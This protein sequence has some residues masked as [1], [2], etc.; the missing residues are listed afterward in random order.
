MADD[1]DETFFEPDLDAEL[2]Q[3][4]D[5]YGLRFG[6]QSIEIGEVRLGK[7]DINLK[8]EHG[9]Q[10]TTC[11]AWGIIHNQPVIISLCIPVQNFRVGE[12]P[13]VCVDQKR[14]I[15]SEDLDEDHEEDQKPPFIPKGQMSSIAAQYLKQNWFRKERGNP[16]K[17]ESSKFFDNLAQLLTMGFAEKNARK[18]LS[19]TKTIEEALFYLT[20]SII[21]TNAEANAEANA[22][23]NGP[24]FVLEKAFETEC[25]FI[26]LANYLRERLQTINEYCVI[27][28]QK[29]LY[30]MQMLQP[31]V[32]QRQLCAFAFQ[33]LNVMADSASYIA[34]QKEVI[35]LLVSM[36][37]LA[38]KSARRELIFKPFPTI[39]A[40]GSGDSSPYLD[41]DKPNYPLAELELAKFNSE[42]I[43]NQ[44]LHDSLM[45][46]M[47]R[48]IVTSNRCYL[49][50]LPPE[51]HIKEIETPHQFILLNAPPTKEARFQKLKL[52]HKTGFGFHGSPAENWH[53][54]LRNGLVNASN[55]KMMTSGAA[56]GSG[57]YLATDSSTSTA[58]MRFYNSAKADKSDRET[59]FLDNTWGCMA[60][61]EVLFDGSE[62]KQGYN[63]NIWVIPNA[64][65]VVTRFLFIFEKPL[66][67][68]VHTK[69]SEFVRQVKSAMN[70]LIKI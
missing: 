38:S 6:K 17:K 11:A 53:S 29:H 50:K 49:A 47:I 14:I 8:F 40:P 48:W 12:I 1:N 16:S 55:T 45:G 33:Q 10:N 30:N 57:I 35:D 27:C 4:L 18:A 37:K 19:A 66:K 2:I 20:N 26:D 43:F 69:G 15:I 5:K 59:F 67:R 52:K 28:D 63:Q 31:A 21:A 3:S 39:F 58:Y 51:H 56:Y 32:C 24:N 70:A 22:E 36:A 68:N 46:P 60:L 7:V 42:T 23:E 34:M 44:S 25:I 65:N 13:T 62:G 64:L 61:C 41:G 9:L 54:I